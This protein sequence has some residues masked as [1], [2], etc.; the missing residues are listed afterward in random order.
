MPLSLGSRAPLFRRDAAADV[1]EDGEP[2]FWDDRD[3]GFKVIG[4][5]ASRAQALE[6]AKDF[7][8]FPGYQ[9]DEDHWLDGFSCD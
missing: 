9:V 1:F 7:R 8:K 3:E 6:V 4:V 5:F 2:V